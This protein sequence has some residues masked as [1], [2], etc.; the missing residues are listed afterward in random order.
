MTPELGSRESVLL[1]LIVFG[2]AVQFFLMGFAVSDL[3]QTPVEKLKGGR[4][5]PW[6]LLVVFVNTIGPI[7]YL[8]TARKKESSP[9]KA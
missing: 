6:A 3:V 9:A 4:K 1:L 5:W 7:I 2:V 8:L